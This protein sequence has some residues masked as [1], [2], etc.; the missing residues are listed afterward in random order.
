MDRP[1]V[2]PKEALWLTL[3]IWVGAFLLST[4]ANWIAYPNDWRFLF[5]RTI[6]SLLG[7]LVCGFMYLA[8]TTVRDRSM[9]LQIVVATALS[10]IVAVAYA[11]VVPIV[12]R[13]LWSRWVDFPAAAPL[14]YRLRNLP[15]NAHSFF[16]NYFAWC[17][18]YFALMYGSMARAQAQRTLEVEALRRETENQLL[19]SQI[20]PHFLFNALNTISSQVLNRKTRAAETSIQALSRHLRRSLDQTH[21]DFVTL[22]MELE[23][24]E[25]LAEIYRARF[26]PRLIVELRLPDDL[27]TVLVPA[28]ISQPLLEN[29]LKFATAGTPGQ[30][31]V[32]VIAEAVGDRLRLTVRDNGE[33]FGTSP[34]GLGSGLRTVERRLVITYGS[35]ASLTRQALPGRGFEAIIEIP[36][37]RPA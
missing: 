19:R 30:I 17:C 23:G 13:L 10:M 15:G 4:L 14:P 7:A 37:E 22:A 8:L 9:A 5:P 27:K 16:W 26:G 2:S 12:P 35:A 29:A 36:L 6:N 3:A 33:P 11:W 34:P 31:E 21:H 24:L 1:G 32:Q 25:D 20:N 28:Q 18:G